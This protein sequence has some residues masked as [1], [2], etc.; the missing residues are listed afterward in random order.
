MNLR[1]TALKHHE[2]GDDRPIILNIEIKPSIT[3]V[4]QPSTRSASN[5]EEQTVDVVSQMEEIRCG[6]EHGER[7]HGWMMDGRASIRGNTASAGGLSWW[8]GVWT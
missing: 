5:R 4:H 1:S 2:G 6:T 7:Q 8:E 3:Y